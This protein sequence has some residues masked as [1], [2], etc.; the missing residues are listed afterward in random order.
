MG[1]C[2]LNGVSDGIKLESHVA[3]IE[4]WLMRNNDAVVEMRWQSCGDLR[5]ASIYFSDVLTLTVVVN[6]LKD[7]TVTR[8]LISFD[9]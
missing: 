6:S 1:G 3:L 4:T 8:W 5:H 2:L 9:G 7:G